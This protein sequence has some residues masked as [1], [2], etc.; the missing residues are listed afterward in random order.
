VAAALLALHAYDDTLAGRVWAD[1]DAP[2]PHSSALSLQLDGQ[3]EV[4]FAFN[5]V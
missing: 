4:R 1:S 2:R 3:S 5:S